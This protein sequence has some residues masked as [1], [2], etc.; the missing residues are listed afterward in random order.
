MQQ[1]GRFGK[2][3]KNE[4]VLT[5]RVQ[6]TQGRHSG[7]EARVV[8]EGDDGGEDGGRGRGAARELGFAVDDYGIAVK[9]IIISSGTYI[10]TSPVARRRD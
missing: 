1:T 4:R 10:K 3:N 9:N 8:E 7:S 5:P 6:E 2:K